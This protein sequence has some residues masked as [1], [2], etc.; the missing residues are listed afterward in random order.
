MY[1]KIYFLSLISLFTSTSTILASTTY[2]CWSDASS[3]F[4]A[5][6]MVAVDCLILE[7][8]VEETG[9]IFFPPDYL[10]F[11]YGRCTVDVR[12]TGYSVGM[13]VAPENI[14]DSFSQLFSRCQN[15]WFYYDWGWLNAEI[16]GHS[17]WKKRSIETPYGPRPARTSEETLKSLRAKYSQSKLTWNSTEDIPHYPAGKPFNETTETHAEVKNNSNSNYNATI[18]K[19]QNPVWGTEIYKFT[20]NGAL[21]Y[22]Y[23]F[24]ASGVAQPPTDG[25]FLFN[26]RNSIWDMMWDAYAVAQSGVRGTKQEAL[27]NGHTNAVAMV[28]QLGS[29]FVKNG[30]KDAILGVG[31]LDNAYHIG[32]VMFDDWKERQSEKVIYHLTNGVRECIWRFTVNGIIGTTSSL[33]TS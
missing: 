3:Q 9:L 33:P 5:D 20:V 26:V 28:A 19:R 2:G 6:C 18:E 8:Y 13:N 1:S 7:Q 21:Y 27:I 16:R 24:K 12:I 15:G 23:V 22:I 31:G 30:W 14:Q 4:H 11:G 10:Y 25:N 32:T 17:G 29:F